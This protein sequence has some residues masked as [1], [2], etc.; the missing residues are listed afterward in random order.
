MKTQ[1]SENK[2]ERKL[3]GNLTEIDLLEINAVLKTAR[4]SHTI[5]F[6]D[7]FIDPLVNKI[8]KILREEYEYDL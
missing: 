7:N 5:W 2:S 6:N 4:H 3:S 1:L 8:N